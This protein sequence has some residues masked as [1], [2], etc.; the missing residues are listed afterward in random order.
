MM[1]DIKNSIDTH[2]WILMAAPVLIVGIIAYFF[3]TGAPKSP[4]QVA[5]PPS[6]V[7]TTTNGKATN[8]QAQ[9][10]Q[11]PPQT[12][13][14]GF[15]AFAFILRLL[16]L[17]STTPTPTTTPTGLLP[18]R[19][20]QQTGQSPQ[21]AQTGNITIQSG[22]TTG[23]S[24]STQQNSSNTNSGSGGSNNGSSPANGGSSSN[25][26]PIIFKA[27]D[28]GT[29]EYY[30]P[31]TPPVDITWGRYVNADDRFSIDYPTNWQVEKT[32]YNGHEGISLYLPG[33]D[34]SNPNAQYIGFGMASYYLLPAVNSLESTY[35]YG[36]VIGSTNGTMYTQGVLGS[37]SVAAVFSYE[38]GSF[39]LGSNVSDPDFIYVYNYM[40]Q[41]LTF[42]PQ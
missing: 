34:P 27:P 14:S 37:G 18:P 24:G 10:A 23:G 42:G 2:P 15:N 25:Q 1:E 38:Q 11:N 29:Q 3:L 6:I 16:G 13:N 39:G 20:Y 19:N 7:S 8:T 41:S 22:S 35:T 17:S 5:N 33:T 36:I 9:N 4:T 32:E 26:I 31:T 12:Q 40:L 30:P 28:G 21:T